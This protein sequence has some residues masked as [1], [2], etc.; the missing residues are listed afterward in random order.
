MSVLKVCYHFHF[1]PKL[2]SPL[3]F[4]TENITCHFNLQVT[5]LEHDI[6]RQRTNGTLGFGLKRKWGQTLQMGV[7]Q[8][9]L[10][11]RK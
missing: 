11:G 4:L 9:K 2:I 1:N 10:H 6:F 3:G 7:A 5:S 8:N